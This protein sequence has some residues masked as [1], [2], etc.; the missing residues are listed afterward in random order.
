MVHSDVPVPISDQ[1]Q[2]GQTF[3]YVIFLLVGE[4]S[5]MDLFSDSTVL[6]RRYLLTGDKVV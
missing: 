3:V 2:E 6:G 4:I 1:I 5:S